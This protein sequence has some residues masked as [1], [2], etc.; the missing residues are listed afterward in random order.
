PNTEVENARV[1]AEGTRGE[2]TRVLPR[3][4][5]GGERGSPRAGTGP[6]VSDDPVGVERDPVARPRGAHHR[7]GPATAAQGNTDARRRRGGS[8]DEQERRVGAGE[9]GGVRRPEVA[10]AERA[11]REREGALGR[12]PRLNVEQLGDAAGDG[13]GR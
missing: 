7:G 5:G 4:A 2:V 12:I 6:V 8:V 9:L 1:A 10:A 13:P 3:R 11:S